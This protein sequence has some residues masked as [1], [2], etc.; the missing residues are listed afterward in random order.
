MRSFGY[1]AIAGVLAVSI[2]AITI[3]GVQAA[4]E[5]TYSAIEAPAGSA[6]QGH[7]TEGIKQ[8]MQGK[9]E[10]A[11]M[12]FGEAVKADDKMAE[13]HYNH[14]LA[15][16][17]LGKHKEATE[18]FAQALKLAPNNPSIAESPI[19]KAHLEKMKKN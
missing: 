2:A 12:H 15:L 17:K 6:G 19:L 3:Q 4:E 14:A 11:E 1:I 9:W 13:A 10:E 16:D 18:E 5:K 7:N 8:Y